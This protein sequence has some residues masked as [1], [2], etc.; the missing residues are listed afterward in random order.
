VLDEGRVRSPERARELADVGG[1]DE[2]RDEA[3]E[4]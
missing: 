1:R 2:A 3:E 4:D